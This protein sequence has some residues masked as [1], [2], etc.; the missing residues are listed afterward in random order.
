VL[1]AIEA[2]GSPGGTP[3]TTLVI[4]SARVE[5]IVK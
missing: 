1:R 4:R 3:V 2:R 5:A